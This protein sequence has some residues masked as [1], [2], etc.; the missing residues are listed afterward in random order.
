LAHSISLNEVRRPDSSARI[1]DLDFVVLVVLAVLTAL[2][3]HAL[4]NVALPGTSHYVTGEQ[5]RQIYESGF[6]LIGALVLLRL[7]PHGAFLQLR[8]TI[9]VLPLVL[10][11]IAGATA[12]TRGIIGFGFSSVLPDIGLVEYSLLI[13]IVA[14]VVDTREKALRLL[15]IVFT[16]GALATLMFGILLARSPGSSLLVNDVFA[17]KAMY[18]ALFALPVLTRLFL[19]DRVTAVEVIIAVVGVVLIS[20]TVVRSAVL[21]LVAAF[22]AVVLLAPR[23]RRALVAIALLVTFGVSVGGAV[24]TE[25]AGLWSRF[26]VKSPPLT[27]FVADDGLT[28]FAGGREVSGD[29]SSGRLAREVARWK[30]LSVQLT[31]LVP[32][33]SYTVSF[34]IKPLQSVVTRGFVGSTSG[35][36]WG[37][38]Y[39]K[40]A[41]SRTWQHLRETLRA[42]SSTDVLGLG[43]MYGSSAAL[44]DAVELRR[45]AGPGSAIVPAAPSPKSTSSARS[46]LTGEPPQPST[47]AKPQ[48][49]PPS[50]PN[51]EDEN[52]SLMTDLGNVGGGIGGGTTN[53]SEANVSWRLA[54]WAHDL[55]ATLSNPVFGV[56]FGRPSNFRWSGLVYDGR[57]GRGGIFDVI[58]PHN[59]FVNLVY[60][61]GLLGLF[62]LL[63]LVAVAAR[64]LVRALR[65]GALRTPER[66]LL[67]GCAAV[68]V[69]AAVMA[70]FNAA[71]EAPYMAFFFWVF[72]GILLVLPALLGPDQ[73]RP[74][75]SRDRVSPDDDGRSVAGRALK[76]VDAQLR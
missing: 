23:D 7:R 69:F 63:A 71:L 2:F 30:P 35:Y 75:V 53:G 39:W 32:G 45:E 24:L 72:L 11:W 60:R 36:G 46:A 29:A 49:T 66:A 27:R 50:Q 64:R 56:G 17:A 3:G 61:T 44:L 65:F 13:P 19:R 62:A 41:P 5:A 16:S 58:A 51:G 37:Q 57:T 21:G 47:Q 76:F 28:A 54:F 43:T 74:Q 55:K 52:S 68:F 12:A 26:T 18:M 70:S 42:T 25:W 8:R 15:A 73:A 1:W 48:Q 34:A 59:S 22:V 20:V 6:V 31:G 38:K 10:L 14:L 33:R 4:A 9:P 40:A 67:I